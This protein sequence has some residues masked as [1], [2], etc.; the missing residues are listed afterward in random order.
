MSEGLELLALAQVAARLPAVRGDRRP[1]RSTL[2]RWATIGLLSRRGERVRLAT[3]FVGGTRCTTM[4]DLERFFAE[5]NDVSARPVIERALSAREN[6]AWQ[7]R[8]EAAEEALRRLGVSRT[9]P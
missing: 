8:C 2:H 6:A 4:A 5:K 1:S 9:A 7:R 3:Q